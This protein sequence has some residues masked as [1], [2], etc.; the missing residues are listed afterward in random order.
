VERLRLGCFYCIFSL[1]TPPQR[2]DLFEVAAQSF[3][4]KLLSLYFFT[5]TNT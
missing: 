2:I 3:Q 1:F 5:G 4:G